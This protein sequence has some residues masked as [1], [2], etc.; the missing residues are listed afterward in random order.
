[1]PTCP[2]S[3][4]FAI[5]GVRFHSRLV[6]FVAIFD[7]HYLLFLGN[8]ND[9][10]WACLTLHPKYV[11][12]NKAALASVSESRWLVLLHPTREE[13]GE[14][15]RGRV[16]AAD[17]NLS[18]FTTHHGM[19]RSAP[20][21]EFSLE[22]QQCSSPRRQWLS[23]C[24]E[25]VQPPSREAWLS[26]R[27][28]RHTRCNVHAVRIG[29]RVLAFE[30]AS[31]V[32]LLQSHRVSPNERVAFEQD[33]GDACL[34]KVVRTQRGKTTAMHIFRVDRASAFHSVSGCVAAPKI[35]SAASET[36]GTRYRF[37]A[38]LTFEQLSTLAGW[39]GC[40]AVPDSALLLLT[41]CSEHG[42]LRLCPEDSKYHDHLDVAIELPLCESLTPKDVMTAKPFK[43]IKTEKGGGLETKGTKGAQ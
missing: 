30:L 20:C 3:C 16:V 25:G 31:A 33:T 35:T 13:T 37:T 18:G 5:E 36:N 14:E 26:S 28:P 24:S 6:G 10:N 32:Q 8:I 9:T 42:V 1:M 19:L 40:S 29:A 39:V 41:L 34:L 4:L 43:H 23:L 17:D 38:E 27:F 21:S 12:T 11:H 15:P 2:S 22:H 7:E